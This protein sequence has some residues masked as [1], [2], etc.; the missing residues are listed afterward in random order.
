MKTKKLK[1]RKVK[2]VS[3]PIDIE[4]DGEEKTYEFEY[5]QLSSKELQAL[6]DKGFSFKS[7]HEALRTN[8]KCITEGISEDDCEKITDALFEAIWEESEP[9]SWSEQM[10]ELM[11]NGSKKK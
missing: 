9:G 11:G 7:Q 10:N 2:K 5:T 1:I 3:Y 8:T 6:S 4:I